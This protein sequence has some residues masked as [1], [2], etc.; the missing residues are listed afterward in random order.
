MTVF[1]GGWEMTWL[2]RNRLAT[3][4]L[5]AGMAYGQAG[6]PL[7]STVPPQSETPAAVLR[8]TTRV[9]AISAVVK[10]HDGAPATGLTKQDFELKQ[11]GKPEEIRYFSPGADL[12]LTLALLVDTSGSQ[13]T[14]IGDETLASDVFLESMLGRPQDRATVVQFDSRVK[15]LG[16]M[17]SSASVLHM[18]LMS[19]G[20]DPSANG[21]TLLN[22]TV[23]VVAEKLLA[24]ETGRKAMILLTDG[25]DHGSRSTLEQA[26]E[27]AQKA[28]VQ[29]YSILYS[30]AH[31]GGGRPGGPAGPLVVDDGL[32]ALQK[33]SES[34]G[35]QVFEV[36]KGHSLRQI[37]AEIAQDL[38]LQYQVGYVPPPN[39]KPGSYHRLELRPKDRHLTLEARKGFFAKP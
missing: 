3:S 25:G 32:R 38:R 31:E 13:R 7:P 8:V 2:T 30:E 36:S 35:G 26:V 9:V 14:F 1:G 21:G 16:P 37:Y 33:L 27:Q 20:R 17:T 5:L 10:T 6:E 12:P 39:L 23:G 28:D 19:L 15:M 18:G 4:L 11:D 22:D 34:T 24:K 29:V